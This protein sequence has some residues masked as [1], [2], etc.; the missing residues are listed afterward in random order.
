LCQLILWAFE[1][2]LSFDSPELQQATDNPALFSPSI[3]GSAVF[4]AQHAMLRVGRCAVFK[5][6]TLCKYRQMRRF[7][8]QHDMLRIQADIAFRSTKVL[9]DSQSPSNWLSFT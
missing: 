4:K 5:V 6:S 2:H 3:G 1:S 9:H 8:S 7:Q